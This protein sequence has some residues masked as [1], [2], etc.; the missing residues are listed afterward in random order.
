MS[1]KIMDNFCDTFFTHCFDGSTIDEYCE[2]WV[3]HDHDQSADF[4]NW[5]MDK[6]EKE[7][8]DW[9]KAECADDNGDIWDI[10]AEL[11]MGHAYRLYK[12]RYGKKSEDPT[13]AQLIS[14]LFMEHI[15]ENGHLQAWMENLEENMKE[16]E[17]CESKEDAE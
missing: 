9:I 1:A 2:K 16:I 12:K 6:V 7:L 11:D 10:A 15:M 3:D 8:N 14:C 17:E 4:G 5:C 13:D